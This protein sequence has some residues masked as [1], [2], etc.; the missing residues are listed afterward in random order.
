[1]EHKRLLDAIDHHSRTKRSID[2]L[3]DIENDVLAT[4]YGF[5]EQIKNTNWSNIE[6]AKKTF[7]EVLSHQSNEEI[8][9]MEKKIS[10]KLS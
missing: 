6:C 10:T 2:S 4:K 5:E 1:M 9:F 7:C 3:Q 8:I